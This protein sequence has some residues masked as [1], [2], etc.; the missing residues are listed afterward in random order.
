MQGTVVIEVVY[1]H[2]VNTVMAIDNFSDKLYE[3]LLSIKQ[4]YFCV[5]DFNF[6]LLKILNNNEIRRYANM[7]RSCN[8]TCLINVATRITATS[9]TSIDHI[10][11]NANTSN[12]SA[13]VLVTNLIDHLL[14]TQ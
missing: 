12:V 5:G 4:P 1:R 11:T 13:G 3:L 14:S 2:P 7:L 9:K 6:N 8:C 10:Y